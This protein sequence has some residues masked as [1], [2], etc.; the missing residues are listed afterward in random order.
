MAKVVS[1]VLDSHYD[2]STGGWTMV[3]EY[4][5]NVYYRGWQ[6]LHYAD[7]AEARA[8]CYVGLVLPARIG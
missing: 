6:S 2:T 8:K 1:E 4:K 5:E 3:V 7:A